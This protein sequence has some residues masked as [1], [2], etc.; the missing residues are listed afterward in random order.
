MLILNLIDLIRNFMGVSILNRA[1][2]F[3]KEP[4]TKDIFF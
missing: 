1:Q 3:Y 2:M 4:M